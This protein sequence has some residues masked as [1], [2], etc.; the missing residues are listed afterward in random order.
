[1]KHLKTYESLRDKM[2][3]KVLS[4]E[5]K[6]AAIHFDKLYEIWDKFT[7]MKKVKN[8]YYTISHYG[9]LLITY[10]D[11]KT[12]KGN[13][14]IGYEKDHIVKINKG[15]TIYT[16]TSGQ[17]RDYNNEEYITNTDDFNVILKSVINDRY[18][19]NKDII[20]DIK[21]EIKKKEDD[22]DFLNHIEKLR[23]TL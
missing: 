10:C 7:P 6:Y 12:Y 2:T 4:V 19:N 15:W 18:P 16:N 17:N 11:P 20:A 8:V 5:D 21:K 22:L 13:E 9:G 14:E 3:P 1:M 23:E